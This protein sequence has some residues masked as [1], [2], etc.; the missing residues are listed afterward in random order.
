M[1]LQLSHAGACYHALGKHLDAVKDYESAFSMVSSDLGE[2]AR[3]RQFLTFYQREMALYARANVD[4]PVE[5][6]CLDHDLHPIF[7]AGYCPVSRPFSVLERAKGTV[8][9]QHCGPAFHW[10]MMVAP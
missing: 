6:Y 2:D 4:R 1:T 9:K 3:S 7:K 8:A 10:P 5:E